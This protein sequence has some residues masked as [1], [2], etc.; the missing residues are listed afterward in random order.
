MKV[1]ITGRCEA[2]G[3]RECRG[4][5]GRSAD[6]TGFCGRA[7]WRYVRPAASVGAVLYWNANRG[8][9]ITSRYLRLHF[10]DRA[11]PYK[12]SFLF[13]KVIN[14]RIVFFQAGQEAGLY[15]S[16]QVDKSF[17]SRL[18]DGKKSVAIDPK[19]ALGKAKTDGIS[20]DLSI[21]EATPT[22][23]IISRSS[24]MSRS[25]RVSSLIAAKVPCVTYDEMKSVLL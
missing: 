24:A 4:A 18:M 14:F 22:S 13:K 19:A 11:K 16:D 5:H 25:S 17:A 10:I 6:A 12:K 3:G 2:E 15:R 8:I 21:I 7:S 20:Q 23:S 1:N 9:A